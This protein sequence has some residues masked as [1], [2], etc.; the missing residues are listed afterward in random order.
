MTDEA[1]IQI[2]RFFDEAGV[3]GDLESTDILGRI[4]RRFSVLPYENITKIL[5]FAEA[6]DPSSAHR[7]PAEV[8]ADHFR[9][10][11]GGTCFSLTNALRRILR[12]AGFEPRIAMADM[13]LGPDVH[14]ALLLDVGGRTLLLDPGYLLDEPLCLDPS[15]PLVKVTPMNVLSLEYSPD[16]AGYDVFV[17]RR[18]ARKWRYH[19]KTAEVSDETFQDHWDRSFGMNMMKSVTI[20]SLRPEGQR[21]FSRSKLH[22]VDR[23]RRRVTNV[24]GR[25]A[26]II[27]SVFSIEAGI[28]SQA[29]AVL[30]QVREQVREQEHR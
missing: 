3:R 13:K 14:C 23:E 20:S 9:W 28:V 11:T 10:A 17:E 6:G 15:Q 8:L 21:Y 4:V 22:I 1:R 30:E 16:D 19:L 2:D 7:S 24:R 25:E 18:G 27:A 26:D 12:E 5:R 29:C